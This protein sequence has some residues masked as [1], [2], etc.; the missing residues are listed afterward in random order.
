MTI[1]RRI[2]AVV[3]FVAGLFYF[4]EY[5][6]PPRIGGVIIPLSDWRVPLGNFMA[7]LGAFAI[8][9][10]WYHLLKAQWQN[11]ITG[12]DVPSSLGFFAAL[13]SILY[14]GFRHELEK[15]HAPAWVNMGFDLMF[16][17]VFMP[18]VATVFSLLAFYI[19][20]ASYRAF[21]IRNWEATLLMAAA[22][23]VMLAQVPVGGWLTAWIPIKQLQIPYV[24]AW[25]LTVVNSAAQRAIGFGAAVGVLAISLRIW[26]SLERG[27][28]F[29][30]EGQ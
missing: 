19:V 8:G 23:I 27:V 16:N 21:R 3:T 29:S 18:L 10:G 6:L 9:M 11:L 30:M 17:Y 25:L 7:V 14:F 12:R 2:I 28:F 4:L 20:S 22:F 24:G 26:L 5:I 13:I 15:E 1:Q